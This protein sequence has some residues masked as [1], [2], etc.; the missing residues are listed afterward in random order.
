[1]KIKIG[2]IFGGKSVEHEVSIISGIQAINNMDTEKYDIIPIYLS[3]E[4]KMYIGEM[5]KEVKNFKDINNVI[6]NSQRVIMINNNRKI[7]LNRYPEKKFGNNLVDTLDVVFPVVHGTN[8]EDRK[9]ARIL[10]D[11]RYTICTDVMSYHQL[12][13]MDKYV[14]KT[15]LK[16]NDIPVLDALRI[17]DFEYI[18]DNE[19]VINRILDRFELPVIVKPINLGSSVGIKVSKDAK[20]LKNAVEYAFNFSK[21]ILVENA[22]TNL[23]EINCSVLGSIKNCMASECE[24]PLGAGEILSYEDKYISG[25]TKVSGGSKGMTS[26]DRKL[27]ADIDSKTKETIQN[28]A[29]E[30]FKA[31][32]CNGVVRID[33]MIDMDTE[34][35]YVNEINTIPGSLSF[36]LWEATGLKYKDMLTKL[37][38]L[39][40]EKQREEENLSFSYDTNILEGYGGGSKGTKN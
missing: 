7:D 35:I 39:A 36:Y 3:K 6:K 29:I 21:Q 30:T 19:L 12:Y 17:N 20:S 34:D 25:K 8:V 1:M 15:V 28:Y 26:L 37:I 38:D 13:G 9:L 14:M 2:V 31:L 11:V 5:V 27:P 40:I 32:N 4:N 23:K 33:F 22:I 18:E 10:K 24:E 16:D